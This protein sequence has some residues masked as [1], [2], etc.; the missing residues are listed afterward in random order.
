MRQ[1]ILASHV[2]QI[3][4]YSDISHISDICVT[5]ICEA[6]PGKFYSANLIF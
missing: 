3:V 5:D 2:L 6:Y 1:E 4:Q